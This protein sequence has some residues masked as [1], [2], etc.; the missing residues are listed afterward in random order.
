MQVQNSFLFS[1][2]G[3]KQHFFIKFLNSDSLAAGNIYNLNDPDILIKVLESDK[4][5]EFYE[6]NSSL[7]SGS[8]SI[9]EYSPKNK[10]IIKMQIYKMIK[11]VS[12]VYI[13]EEIEFFFTE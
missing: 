5:Q 4:P 7:F 3:Y 6:Q 13:L 2:K 10:I 1:A 8:I 11:G 12:Q 9:R